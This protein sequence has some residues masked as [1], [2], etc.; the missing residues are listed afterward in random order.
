M[1]P[2]LHMGISMPNTVTQ[3][4]PEILDEQIELFFI[5]SGLRNSCKAPAMAKLMDHPDRGAV[6]HIKCGVTDV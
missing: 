2:Q 5:F 3:N 1:V 4:T 6:Q